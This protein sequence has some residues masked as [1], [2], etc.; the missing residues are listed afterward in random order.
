MGR[1]IGVLGP[2]PPTRDGVANYSRALVR[3]L[4]SRESGDRVGIVRVMDGSI[5]TAAPDVVGYL[6]PESRSSAAAAAAALNTF[7]V[8]LIQH[9]FDTYGGPDGDQVLAVLEAVRA[10][11]ITVLH[12]VRTDPNPRQFEII[13]RLAAASHAVVVLTKAAQRT[14]IDSYRADS[15]RV[16]VIRH[17]SPK[18]TTADK[19]PATGRPLVLTW[20]LLTPDKGIEWAIGGLQRLRALRPTPAYILAGPTHPRVVAQCGETYRHALI[21]RARSIEM[22]HAFRSVGSYI[23]DAA[24]ATLL[25]RASV[26]VLPYNRADQTSSP[27]LVEALAAGKPVVATPFP[28]AVELLSGG[29]GLLVPHFD[30]SA[31]G[32]AVQRILAERGLA[33]RMAELA[34]QEATTTWADVADEYRQLCGQSGAVSA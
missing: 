30:A 32:A 12:T 24:L 23:E 14:L 15:G 13:R 26:V 33:D 31:I 10:P 8:V 19:P 3:S 16:R 22:G 5:G 17:G 4:A 11:V 1:S 29:A 21:Q 34:L 27:V 25:H 2:Y 18:R 9:S 7:D 20:G 6:H 28:H